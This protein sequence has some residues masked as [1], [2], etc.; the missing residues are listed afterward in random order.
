MLTDEIILILWQAPTNLS[1]NRCKRQIW[2]GPCHLKEK[3]ATLLM[4]N[5]G[6]FLVPV[7]TYILRFLCPSCICGLVRLPC[8][9]YLW[10]CIM[11][12]R[13]DRLL[14][15]LPLKWINQLV[16]FLCT[17]AWQFCLFFFNFQTVSTFWNDFNTSQVLIECGSAL[18]VWLAQFFLGMKT[19][20]TQ[21]LTKHRAA[22]L[23]SIS[24]TIQM[25]EVKFLYDPRKFI[26]SIAEL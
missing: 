26:V 4:K 11:W 12:G 13:F 17:V 16:I 10:K 19:Y 3:C 15:N 7:Q 18:Y 1:A 25:L 5:Y 24:V 9:W 22:H 6:Y 8:I 2:C 21:T 20:S 14:P 23:K